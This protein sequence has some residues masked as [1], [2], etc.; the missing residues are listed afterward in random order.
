MVKGHPRKACSRLRR[1]P[2]LRRCRVRCDPYQGRVPVPVGLRGLGQP[3]GSQ[4]WEN[5]GRSWFAY[6]IM[7]L[8]NVRQKNQKIT[9]RPAILHTLSKRGLTS[10]MNETKWREL[11]SAVMDE[12]PFAPAFQRKNILEPHPYPETFETNVYYCGDWSVGIHQ[13]SE[14]EWIRV[15]PRR[16]VHRGH[17]VPDAID[18]IEVQFIAVLHR[19]GIPFL[20]ESESILV[21]GYTSDPGALTIQAKQDGSKKTAAHPEST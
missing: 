16:L 20:R 15:R 7:W 4:A 21:Y 18:D 14:I 1:L 6:R 3:A 9:M 11:R 17:L 5:G 12:L 8:H 13:S 10:V 2:H 19:I